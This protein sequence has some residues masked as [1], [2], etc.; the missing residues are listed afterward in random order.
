[1]ISKGA[2]F[3]SFRVWVVPLLSYRG[4]NGPIPSFLSTAVGLLLPLLWL[5]LTGGVLPPHVSPRF[6]RVNDCLGHRFDKL[7]RPEPRDVDLLAAIE[8]RLRHHQHPVQMLLESRR[9]LR[10]RACSNASAFA[11]AA[12]A[13]AAFSSSL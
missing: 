12:A 13:I 3:I 4:G 10:S 7:A 5:R 1:M 6:E 8:V 9:N 11:R 2:A